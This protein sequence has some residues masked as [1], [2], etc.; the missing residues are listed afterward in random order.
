VCRRR[1][2]GGRSRSIKNRVIDLNRQL[3]SLRAPDEIDATNFSSKSTERRDRIAK[4]SP[5][6]KA[7]DRGRAELVAQEDL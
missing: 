6:V 4:L 5:E 2:H 7:S 1:T 3:I